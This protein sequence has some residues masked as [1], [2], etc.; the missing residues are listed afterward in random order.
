MRGR[1]AFLP[2]NLLLLFKVLRVK[3]NQGIVLTRVILIMSCNCVRDELAVHNIR[4]LN[5]FAL[6]CVIFLNVVLL[7]GSLWLHEFSYDINLS[8][9]ALHI[10]Q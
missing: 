5:L 3:T 4:L 7:L 1:S 6:K 10:G 8:L 2:V 9:C